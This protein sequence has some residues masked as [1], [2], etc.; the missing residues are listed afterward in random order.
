MK[1][2]LE[3]VNLNSNSGP[4][5]FAQKLVKYFL[6]QEHSITREDYDAALCFIETRN[7]LDNNK[8]F[9]RLDGIY[10]NSEFNYKAQNSNIFNTYK[11][12]KG[13]IFQSDFNKD[14]TFHY[15]G[16]HENYTVIHNGSDTE[17][18]ENVSP[19]SNETL[20][21]YDNVWS[22]AASWR[23]HKRLKDNIRYF[24]EHQRDN[25]CLVVA[26]KP[27]YHVKEPNIFYVGE[28]DY[29]RLI[30]LYKRSKF[31]LHLAW[32]DHCPNVVV[33][34]RASGCQII[35]SD[36]GGTKEIA[37]LDAIIIKEREWNFKPTRLYEP[38]IMDFSKKVKNP[39][40]SCYNM[41]NVAKR[42]AEFMK[43]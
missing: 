24:L 22:C 7:K 42:Y 26:G 38:P 41:E 32:L 9:Q 20:N 15:F 37:G 4:N 21:K 39:H 40:D 6:R 27:D 23:P 3:N 19:I 34:A 18:V 25:D 17:L 31:F 1:I 13:V 28:L 16:E 2:R 5:S 36:A 10:F 29:N 11:Q 12:A 14:L 35:C 8:L 33:D 30:S 43:S